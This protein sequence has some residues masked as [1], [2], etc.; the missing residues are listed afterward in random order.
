M[1]ELKA[2]LGARWSKRVLAMIHSLRVMMAGVLVA[3]RVGAGP[4]ATQSHW[5]N[6]ETHNFGDGIAA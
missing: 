1:E 4:Y 5:P 3:A 6:S 2:Q